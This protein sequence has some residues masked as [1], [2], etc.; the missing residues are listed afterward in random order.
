M[1]TNQLITTSIDEDIMLVSSGSL[2]HKPDSQPKGRIL[3]MR[4]AVWSSFLLFA[5]VLSAIY[6]YAF[7]TETLFKKYFVGDYV[8]EEY[9][10]DLQMFGDFDQLLIYIYKDKEP[11]FR[12][13]LIYI[14]E[15]FLMDSLQINSPREDVIQINPFYLGKKKTQSCEIDILNTSDTCIFTR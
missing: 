8:A 6:Y 14:S 2:S 9:H 5:I 13:R 7:P 11:L 1:E 10:H 15:Y 3:W 4:L 12:R